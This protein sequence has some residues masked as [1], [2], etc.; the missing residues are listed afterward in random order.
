MTLGSTH[1]VAIVG[2]SLGGLRTAEAL[3]AAG[4]EGAITL[5]GDEPGEPYDRPPLSKQ[6]LTGTWE[7]DRIVL[8][9]A[10]EIRDRL[11]LRH[12]PGH[13]VQGVDVGERVLHVQRGVDAGTEQVGFD[14]LVI[15]TGARVR[16]LPGFDT[17]PR[18]HVVRTLPNA[19]A[20]RSAINESMQKTEGTC[21]VVV[22]GAG[23]IGAE[24]AAAAKSLGA[25]VT[26]LEA[27]PVPLGRQLGDEMGAA[28]GSLHARNGVTLRAGVSV[29]GLSPEGVLLGDG[30]V[31]PAEVIVVG[32]GV[33]PNIEWLEGSGIQLQDGVCCDDR[34]RV[35]DASGSPLSG[36]VAVG[37]VA[38][39]PFR[40]PSGSEADEPESVRIEHW[41]N[42]A[43]SAEHA[44][45]TLLGEDQPYRPIPY[46]WSDQYKHRIQFLGRATGF[47]EVRIV[48]GSVD[49]AAWVALYR[50][51]ER[52]VA[53]LGVSKIRSLM[54]YR[55]LLAGGA[56]WQDALA[57]AASTAAPKV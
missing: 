23:F 24:V 40:F 57:H 15:A 10:D 21:R 18:V 27:A 31:V 55:G 36:V 46:F 11:R 12:L 48:E 33:R 13:A 34:L 4:F 53:A 29:T 35:L 1:H 49:D 44:A 8:R 28:C 26:I 38:R 52:L 54:A 51:G 9:T 39:F 6:L 17:D 7:Q 41:T 47:D 37:D 32:V 5:I 45:R 25:D 3:R 16:N 42:A 22:I 30:S 14:S 2:A 56:T 19:L 43:E 50:R 20:L